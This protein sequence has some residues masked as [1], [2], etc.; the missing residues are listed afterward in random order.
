MK[1]KNYKI[2]DQIDFS[3]QLKAGAKIEQVMKWAEDNFYC[4]IPEDW[5]GSLFNWIN[6][7]EFVNYL[8]KRH[9]GL[10]TAEQEVYY[11]YFF[12]VDDYQ[13]EKEEE[14]WNIN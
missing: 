12:I 8:N 1:Q 9:P 5:G 7:L 13:K 14:I 10:H 4:I 6:E 2:L 11:S 3:S